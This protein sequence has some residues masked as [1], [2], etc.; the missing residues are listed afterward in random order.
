MKYPEK[1]PR[2]QYLF[3]IT[4]SNSSYIWFLLIISAPVGVVM[5]FLLGEFEVHKIDIHLAFL[6]VHGSA[7]WIGVQYEKYARKNSTRLLALI[8]IFCQFFNISIYNAFFFNLTLMPKYHPK[9]S[10]IDEIW[11]EEFK[12]I[13]TNHILVKHFFFLKFIRIIYFKYPSL[14]FIFFRII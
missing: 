3:M 2:W 6:L 13:S 7:F 10:T 14:Q 5:F 4:D 1:F 9:I 11:M 8:M 12:L